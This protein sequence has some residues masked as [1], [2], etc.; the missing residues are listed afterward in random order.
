MTKDKIIQPEYETKFEVKSYIPEL[1]KKE[2]KELHKIQAEMAEHV[3]NRIERAFYETILYGR[4][5]IDVEYEVIS[6]PKQLENK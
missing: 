2:L 5:S 6:E 3:Q 1:S 4:V